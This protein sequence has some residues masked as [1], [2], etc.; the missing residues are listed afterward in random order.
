[1]S[2]AAEKRRAPQSGG[3][4]SG[5]VPPACA[6][7]LGDLEGAEHRALPV[8]EPRTPPGGCAC[9]SSPWV[10]PDG[11]PRRRQAAGTEFPL[12]PRV[13]WI[14]CEL[15]GR[16]TRGPLGRGGTSAKPAC[17]G[18]TVSSD[19][20][21]R[22]GGGQGDHSCAL[23]VRVTCGL[24]LPCVVTCTRFPRPSCRPDALGATLC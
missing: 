13:S 15:S 10:T 4:S 17:V 22:P 20:Q 3:E 11:A 24:C 18:R 14:R 6:Q 9:V 8:N 2:R 1:M 7:E 16:C 12:E 21:K 19:S 23:R 5:Q